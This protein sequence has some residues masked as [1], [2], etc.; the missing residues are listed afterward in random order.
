MSPIPFYR[1][2]VLLNGTIPLLVLIWDVYKGQ[3]GANP[4]NYALHV[5]GILSLVFLFLTL[6]MTPL[7]WLTGWSGWS[8]FRRSLGLYGF[9]YAF[10]HL[11][12]YVGFDRAM[13]LTSTLHE[14]TMRR[15]LQIG[16]AALVL[17][18][19]L[20]V[21]STNSMIR[22]MGGRNWKLLHRLTYLVA[23]LGVVHYYMLVKSDVR[24]PLAFGA[25]LA[26]LL[27]IRVARRFKTSLASPV[28][29]PTS[30][31][32]QTSAVQEDAAAPRKSRRPWKGELRLVHTFQET[33][34]VKTFRLMSCVN[35]EP[36]PFEYRPGQF[37]TL[38]LMIDGKRVNRSYT[39][40][41]SPTRPENCELTIKR[42]PEGLAS[43]FLHDRLSVGDRLSVTAPAGK[44]VFTGGE[45]E[46]VLLISGGVGITPLMS[47]IR[48]LTDR[49]WLGTIYFLIVAR[50][51]RDLI[52]RDEIQYLQQRFS[53]LKVCITLTREEAGSS[54]KGH[55]GRADMSL[56]NQF[57]PG[58]PHVPVYLCGPNDM[59]D[60]TREL[61]LSMGVPSAEIHTEAFAPRSEG[62]PA[63]EETSED[64]ADD[65][66]D[67]ND[68]DETKETAAMT[69]EGG[70]MGRQL[71]T[72]TFSKSRKSAEV[73]L[74]TSVLEAAEMVSIAMKYDC[75]AGV[76]GQCRT[77]LRKGAVTM[78]CT[79]ALSSEDQAKG[80][81]LSCQALPSGNIVVDA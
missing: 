73:T 54:W 51:E 40:A 34:D 32:S 78:D 70:S 27:G 23:I 26:L 13:N 44:F 52:F 38:H 61:L 7:Q 33:H 1:L 76:C 79:S 24:Q 12:I 55:R 5:T 31:T 47:I 50:T 15:F 17:M 11:I 62:L 2:L 67:E 58:L 4:V 9:F 69:G 68:R 74:D 10:V 46:S 30:L 28:M 60:A 71:A 64:A 63:S 18:I 16:T 3:V 81:I 75:R 48:S 39:I 53:N 36:L 59:M 77:R 20:A 56:L 8:A 43:R 42:E 22:R 41:S 65:S 37:L 14:I 29:S 66:F 6:L 57:V 21:T 49:A 72:I 35:D 19:P 45:T 80:W 25:V